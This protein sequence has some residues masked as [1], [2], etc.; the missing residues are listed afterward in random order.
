MRRNVSLASDVCYGNPSGSRTPYENSTER[1]VS[2]VG[3]RHHMQHDNTSS[4]Q[5]LGPP[6]RFEILH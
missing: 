3:A 1:G 4:A 2:M 5:L 6:I